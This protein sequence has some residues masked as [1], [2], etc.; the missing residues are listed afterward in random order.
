MTD[1]GSVHLADGVR[2][3]ISDTSRLAVVDVGM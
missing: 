3:E 1:G 2:I